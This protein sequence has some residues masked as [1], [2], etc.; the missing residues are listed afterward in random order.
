MRGMGKIRAIR[1]QLK[2]SQEARQRANWQRE[3]N[4]NGRSTPVFLIGNHRSGT[5]M[6]VFHLARS[7]RVQLYNEDHPA[8]FEQWFIKSFDILDEL[9]QKSYAE[10]VLF[11]PIRDTYQMRNLQHRFPAAKFLFSYRHYDDVVNSAYKKFYVVRAKQWGVAPEQL[12]IPV[13][14]W[15]SD[16]FAEFAP[17]PP[18][19][20]TKAL[21]GSLW[22]P[23]MD[24]HSKVALHWL[25]FNRLYF[26]LQ[27]AGD[28][29]V[30]L[31]G[32]EQLVTDPHAEFTA[33]CDFLG[34]PFEAEMLADVFASSIGRKPGPALDPAVTAACEEM[35]QRLTAAQAEQTAVS[36]STAPTDA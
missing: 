13:D 30:W 33:V 36:T 20:E 35:W 21:I 1:H 11:K 15:M 7:L 2:T 16:D 3:N 25:F 22:R 28:P 14:R 26:D 17:A 27:M 32:Y 5:S 12:P 9:I 31:V 34:L 4:P 10:F 6:L 8:A 19:A 18:T 29:A 24:L 23:E